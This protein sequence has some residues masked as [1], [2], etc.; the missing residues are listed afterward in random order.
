[1]DKINK[2]TNC[3]YTVGEDINTQLESVYN[4]RLTLVIVN[5]YYYYYYYITL[6]LLPCNFKFNCSFK[7]FFTLFSFSCYKLIYCL[8]SPFICTYLCPCAAATPGFVLWGPIKAHL[9]MCLYCY[10]NN[11]YCCRI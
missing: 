7:V 3:P 6:S 1:M 11:S 5:L 2:E 8:L 4:N 9:I 10:E